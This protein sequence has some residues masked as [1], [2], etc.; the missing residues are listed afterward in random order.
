[1]AILHRA[2]RP[3]PARPFRARALAPVIGAIALSAFSASLLPGSAVAQSVEDARRQREATIAERAAA[4]SELSVLGAQDAELRAALASLD[5]ALAYHATWLAAAEQE[6]IAA[7]ARAVLRQQ[8][9][10][11]TAAEIDAVRQQA[12]ATMVKAYIGAN[13]GGDDEMLTAADANEY[14]QRQTLL[15]MVEGRHHDHLDR[16]RALI[17]DQ[18]RLQ[19]EAAEAA[20]TAARLRDEVAA[21]QAQLQQEREA[22]GRV[23]AELRSRIDDFEGKVAE[24]DAAEAQ[25]NA[26]I[27]E[28][29]RAAAAPAAPAARAAAAPVSAAVPASGSSGYAYPASGPVTSGFGYRRH[30]VLGTSRLHAGLDI[31]ASYGT[32]IWASKGGVVILAG[33]NGGYGNCVMIDHGDGVVTLYGHMSSILV[34]DGES[35]SQGQVIGLIGSTG[36]STGPHLHFETR[37]GGSPENPL[38]YIG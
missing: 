4:A 25:L 5:E 24:L 13:G 35:V 29:Q 12:A 37:V 26:V 31:G 8:E 33:W 21:T 1:M 2:S 15:G 9:A 23:E 19:A 28:R 20:A 18:E 7:E 34:S 38:N 36:M 16:L 30:P 32:D 22:Q 6:R 27:D 14:V 3:G 10:V 17:E 11:A